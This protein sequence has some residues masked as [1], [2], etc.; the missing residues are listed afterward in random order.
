MERTPRGGVHEADTPVQ[1]R[2]GLL[3]DSRLGGAPMDPEEWAEWAEWAGGQG[4]EEADW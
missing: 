3:D 1:Q 2:I 4:V